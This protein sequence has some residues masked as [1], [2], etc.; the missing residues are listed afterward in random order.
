[1]PDGEA[2]N[3]INYIPRAKTFIGIGIH[4]FDVDLGI[5]FPISRS[6][7]SKNIDLQTHIATKRWGVDAMWQRFNKFRPPKDFSDSRLSHTMLS[8]YYVFNFRKFSVKAVTNQNEYQMRSAGTVMIHTIVSRLNLRDDELIPI[9]F[10]T[11]YGEF[12]DVN[13]YSHWMW[14]I[15]PGYAYSHVDKPFILSGSLAIGAAH[16]WEKYKIPGQDIS[17]VNIKPLYQLSTYLGVD[18]RSNFAGIRM[19][20]RTFNSGNSKLDN[21]LFFYSVRLAAGHRFLEKGPLKHGLFEF[22]KRK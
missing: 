10:Q 1:M 2:S 9:S 21:R 12:S 17:D 15:L 6:P 8:G 3:K 20:L 7:G 19:E 4:L 18:F 11:D 22:F 14:A 5:N 16:Y 13:S